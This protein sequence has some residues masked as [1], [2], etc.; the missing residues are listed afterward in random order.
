MTGIARGASGAKV[1]SIATRLNAKNAGV[2]APT[3][4]NAAKNNVGKKSVSKN[5][6]AA[7]KSVGAK[8]KVSGAKRKRG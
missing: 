4:K 1:V 6:A 3:K 2:A 5:K 7:K 8:K